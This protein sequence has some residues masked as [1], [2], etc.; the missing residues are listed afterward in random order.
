MIRAFIVKHLEQ[1]KSIP[2]LIE[3]LDA[4]PVLTEMCGFKMGS[5]PDETQ[6]YRFLK[7]TPNSFLQGIH[8]QVNRKLNKEGVLSLDTFV[9][10]SKPV[11]AATQ[12]N[13]FKNPKWNSKDK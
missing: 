2:R 4:H 7:E 13:N 3:F 6:F 1:I 11:M 10:D 12:K 9:I 8:T 5:L